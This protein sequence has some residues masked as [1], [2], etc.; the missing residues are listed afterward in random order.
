[1][2]LTLVWMAVALALHACGREDPS[3]DRA[4][5]ETR[6]DESR[7]AE[8]ASDTGKP[9]S[10][11]SLT[12]IVRAALESASS[13]DARKIDVENRNGN[14]SLHGTVQSDEQREKAGRIV[15]SVGGVRNVVNNL[16]VD[17]SASAGPT[18]GASAPIP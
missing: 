7:Q 6:I 14:V 16:N 1:M 4:K 18:A 9:L 5:A 15:A 10:D 12:Q 13:L 11:T 17:P 3:S 2:R 8:K